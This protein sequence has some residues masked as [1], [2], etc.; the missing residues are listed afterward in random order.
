MD[1]VLRP[2]VGVFLCS[3]ARVLSAASTLVHVGEQD[4]GGAHE[5]HVEAGVEHV[6]GRHAL[7][8]EARLRPDD[9]RRDGSGRR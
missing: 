6:R 8:D 2:M 3:K 5:L 7:V 1:A 9:A 4:V